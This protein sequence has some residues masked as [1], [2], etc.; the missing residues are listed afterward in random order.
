MVIKCLSESIKAETT[1]ENIDYRARL[2]SRRGERQ[3]LITF[4][5]FSK[6]LELLKNKI[7]LAGPKDRVDEVISTVARRIRKNWSLT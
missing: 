4:A 1:I 6:K 5:S 7:N 2:G 3:I